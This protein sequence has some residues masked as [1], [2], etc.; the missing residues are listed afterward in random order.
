MSCV[1]ATY[2]NSSGWVTATYLWCSGGGPGPWRVLLTVWGLFWL[3]SF[4]EK[5]L[6]R[7]PHQNYEAWLLFD[8]FFREVIPWMIFLGITKPPTVELK[9]NGHILQSSF[10]NITRGNLAGF[11]P[12]LPFS[13]ML[14]CPVP[15]GVGGWGFADCPAVPLGLSGHVVGFLLCFYLI[16][17]VKD[18]G[19]SSTETQ[20]PHHWRGGQ[21]WC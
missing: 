19:K 17:L 8:Y 10:P 1:H 3:G 4:L 15:A 13:F 18:L 7:K 14:Q 21:E 2:V 12:F 20:N 5:C 11:I 9:A 6:D 16:C